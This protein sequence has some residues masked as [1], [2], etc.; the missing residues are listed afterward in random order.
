MSIDAKAF[1]NNI[2]GRPLT[3]G[4]LVASLRKTDEITQAELAKALNV[5]KGLIC[6]IEKGR[7][8]AS[9]ELAIKMA[10]AMGYP[11]EA[12]IV[13]IFQDK[14]NDAKIKLKVKLEAA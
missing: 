9:I 12:M 10:K 6:D 11:R 5:S 7:R 1:L 3:F 4:K 13:Q 8:T 2:R 14:L